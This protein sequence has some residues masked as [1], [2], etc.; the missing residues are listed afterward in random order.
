M[1]C[2]DAVLVIAGAG[3]EAFVDELRQS[4]ARLKIDSRMILT[5]FLSGQEKLAA[6]AAASMFALPSYSEN[7]G[8]AAVEALASGLPCVISDQVGIASDVTEFEAGL[9]VPCRVPE[10]AAALTRMMSEPQLRSRTGANAR[11]LAIR[12]F[13]TQAMTESLVRLYNEKCGNL[14]SGQAK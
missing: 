1:N 9:V 8:I 14:K 11:R 6:F 10:L 4:A 13:S 3:D 2:P 12:R 5:G 7:F